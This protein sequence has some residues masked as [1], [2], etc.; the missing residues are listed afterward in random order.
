MRACVAVVSL[1]LGL[2]AP[3]RGDVITAGSVIMDP[4]GGATLQFQ[5][6]GGFT[7]DG[8]L[9]L[10]DGIWRGGM[11]D[12]DARAMDLGGYWVGNAVSGIG[13]RNGISADVGTMT[14]DHWGE[15]FLFGHV[16]W[17][18]FEDEATVV[19]GF[20]M[21][22]VFSFLAERIDVE[23]NGLATVLMQRN[24]DGAF[25]RT[26]SYTFSGGDPHPE[27]ATLLLM[28]SGLLG[29]ARWRRRHAHAYHL[30]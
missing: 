24:V 16:S 7:F 27:P 9:H 13:T 3:A 21:R 5:T 25:L 20:S 1:M 23:G 15:L 29:L 11:A 26:I 28:G 6:D 4:Y 22:G 18:A 12:S 19:T 8:G 14:S 30:D 10:S 2:V 17:D